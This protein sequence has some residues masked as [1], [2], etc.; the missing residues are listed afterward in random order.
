MRSFKIYLSNGF[1]LALTF[2]ILTILSRVFV[3]SIVFYFVLKLSFLVTLYVKPDC[4]KQNA[5]YPTISLAFV[6]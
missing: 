6:V 4:T 5:S 2:I 3:L 1:K